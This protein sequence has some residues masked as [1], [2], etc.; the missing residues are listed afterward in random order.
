MP[1][2]DSPAPATLRAKVQK[3]CVQ[4]TPLAIL[5]L[6]HELEATFE[7][8]AVYPDAAALDVLIFSTNVIGE[9]IQPFYD[10]LYR[11]VVR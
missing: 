2:G 4:K 10:F 6:R 5:Q 7:L 11:F 3:V 1:A 8:F 9:L